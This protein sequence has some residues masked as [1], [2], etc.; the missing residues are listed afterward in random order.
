MSNRDQI[1]FCYDVSNDFFRLW[2]DRELNYTCA[3]FEGDEELEV[4]QRRKLEWHYQK[5]RITPDKR[6]L[7]IGCGWG[8]NLAFLSRD[9]GVKRSTGITLSQAQGDEIAQRKLNG[10]ELV[11]GDVREFWPAEKY[12]AVISICMM[13]HLATPEEAREGR[14]LDLYREF[15]RRVHAWTNPG[16]WFGLQTIIRDRLPRNRQDLE[17]VFWVTRTIFPGGISLRLEDIV[18]SVGPHWEIV[19][20][21]TRRDDYRKTCEHWLA[22]LRQHE[23]TIRERWGEQ[24]FR[25]HER[26][27]ETCIRCFERHYQSLAQFALK[28]C[29]HVTG[30]SR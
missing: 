2:L 3:L 29:D 5:A 9:K 4:A 18:M 22:R 28:R 19:E 23:G 8:A 25:D 10:V 30:G 21:A 17:D 24:L 20:V 15:F 12:D 26:Y 16:S 6:V 13:E 7:D 1:A 11:V 27:F 14:H